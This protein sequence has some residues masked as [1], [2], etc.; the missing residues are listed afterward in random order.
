MIMVASLITLG[1]VH[2]AQVSWTTSPGLNDNEVS[3][4]GTQLFGYYY[5]AAGGPATAVVNSVPFTL[6]TG[7]PAGLEFNGGYNNIEGTDLYQVAPTANNA[8]LNQIL[9]GQN[10]GGATPLTVT[11]LTPGQPY[12]LQFMISDDR[13]GFNRNRNYDVSDGND[14]EGSRDIER[15]YH[16]TFGTGLPPAAPAGSREAKI[17]S[18][19]FIADGTGTQNIFN[20]LYEGAD[21]TGGNSGSQVNAIQVRVIPE[22]S[23]LIMLAGATVGIV[24]LRRRRSLR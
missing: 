9:D 21:H 13:P 18:G 3:T 10:W 8:G 6:Q 5:S 19:S 22:P 4:Q 16:S 17:F 24:A 11:G 23:S 14:P 2:A 12:E 15:A 1:P 20:T 7:Q